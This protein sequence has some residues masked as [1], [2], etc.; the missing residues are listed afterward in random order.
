MSGAFAELDHLGEKP[1]GACYSPG[2]GTVFRLWAPSGR[3]VQLLLCAPRGE[4][5][6]I[7]LAELGGGFFAALVPG[8]MPG[9]RYR[10]EVDG[11]GPFP[12][13]ASHFQPED[14][15]GPSEVIDPAYPWTDGAWAGPEDWK[16]AVIYELHVGAFTPEGT[17]AGV[18]SRLDHLQDLGITAI[19]LMPV[20]DFPGRW[21]WGYDGAFQFAPDASY[22]R[23]GQFKRLVN[24]CHN[25]GIA[26][27]L[28]VVY[29]HFG[30]DGNYLWPVCREFFNE[31]WPTPWGAGIDIR[32]PEVVGFFCQNARYWIEEYHLDGL[33]FDAV[34]ALHH[35]HRRGFLRQVQR[36]ARTAAHPRS[37]FLALENLDNETELL[38]GDE[39]YDAQ[40]NDDFHHAVHVLLTG[41]QGAHYEDF[42][43]PEAALERALREGLVFQGQHA[44]WYGGSRGSDTIGL[45]L[46]RFVN[47]LQ[48]HDMCGNRALGERLHQL[49]D[50]ASY[51]AVVALYLS[52]P[53]I[54]ML[55]M[56]E[57]FEASTPFLFFTDHE[58]E[59]GAS[60]RA[61]R[62]EQH[63]RYDDWIDARRQGR[64][65]D[66]QDEA[67]FCA[68]RL[69]WRERLRNAPTLEFYRRL[70]RLRRHYLPRVKHDQASIEVWRDG[71]LF[72]VVMPAASGHGGL[73]CVM[74]LGDVPRAL[75]PSVRPPPW[76]VAF[77]T[78]TMP[79]AKELPPRSTLWLTSGMSSPP[80]PL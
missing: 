34:H 58:T 4:Q 45:S 48:T 21:N 42:S 55:F 47:L 14:V 49:T 11:R 44:N 25:R 29:N 52:L 57:E 32:R 50:E 13:P 8:V 56:G 12:D 69:D 20:A 39:A 67:T 26:V 66:P 41:E 70:I 15:H 30:P 27:L 75:P 78:T 71:R 38:R 22:G 74:N 72:A 60:V 2:R 76:N 62:S 10:F 79:F 77:S 17:F 28:D 37:I 33:R 7:R 51:H 19:E 18:E 23:P 54:P 6:R 61:G 31:D 43:V 36:A 68:S 64:M 16:R 73:A 59:L 46:D 35:D 63:A 80:R 1:F 3:E 9:W 5:R 53:G 24:H 40:W 65:V